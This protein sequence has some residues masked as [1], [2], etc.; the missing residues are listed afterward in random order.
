M[1]AGSLPVRELREPLRKKLPLPSQET[2]EAIELLE[3]GE[4]IKFAGVPVT[5]ADAV[6]ARDLTAKLI[7]R[8]FPGG[9][10]P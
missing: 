4:G 10:G 5:P 1:G 3:R 8:L 7:G 2:A 9:G 6:A